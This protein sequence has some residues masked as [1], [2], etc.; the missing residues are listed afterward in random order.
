MSQVATA[1]KFGDRNRR[2][3]KSGRMTYSIAAR[4]PETGAMGVAVQSHWFSVGSVVVAASPGVGAIAT[5]ANPDLSNTPRGLAILGDGMPAAEVSRAL[6]GDDPA[7]AHRQFA[8]VD[9]HGGAVG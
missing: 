7:A 5:Q 6:L 9:M 1:G 2:K 3:W 4:D 8:V